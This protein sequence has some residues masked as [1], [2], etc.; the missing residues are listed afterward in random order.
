MATIAE[1]PLA[2]GSEERFFLRAAIVMALIIVAGFSLDLALGRSTFHSPPLLHA[3][4][5]T[6]M[7]WMVIY[8]LQNFLVAGGRVD[9]HRRLGWIA[10]FWVA[11]MVIL[12]TI[13]TVAMVRRGGAPFFFRPLQFLVFDPIAVLTFA[14]LTYAGVALRRRTDWHRR[15]NYCGM[16]VLLGPAFG[17]LLPMPL[18]APWAY[19]TLMVVILIFP[20]VGWWSDVRRT[21]HGHPAWRWGMVAIVGS[22]LLTDAITYSPVGSAIYTGVTAGSPGAA[23]PPLA[24]PPPPA[25]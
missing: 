25:G 4:A 15:L 10:V 11:A 20:A 6:F 17:R 22:V 9:L 19:E 16:S 23:V 8:L 1:R 18:L 7:G 24:F 13:V 5:I 14:G 3:H 21:G 2:P 12:G